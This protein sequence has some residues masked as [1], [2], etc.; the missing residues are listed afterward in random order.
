MSRRRRS[1]KLDAVDP[2]ARVPRAP[3]T[4]RPSTA[5]SS[6]SR[7]SSGRSRSRSQTRSLDEW[8]TYLRWQLV[9][10]FAAEAGGAFDAEN[11]HFF[12][13][14]LNGTPEQRPRWKRMLDEEENYLGDALGQL[15]VAALLLAARRRQRY[16][17]LTDEIFARVPRAHRRAR[18]DERRDEGSARC[19]KLDAVTKKVGY[20]DSWRTTRATT[21]TARRSSAT[22]MR[23]NVWRSDY[24]IAKLHKPV[25]RTEWEMTPQTYNAY[26]NPSN[27]EIV[28]PAAVFILPGIADSLVD[29]AIVYALRRRHDDRPRDHARLRRPGPPVRRAGQPRELVDAGGR[30]GVQRA[31]PR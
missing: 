23:G 14:I 2:L 8:K 4:S 28:L 27:N 11:F 5:S 22:V 15:Y 12:G 30:E 3:A 17:K 21:S 16:E 26:Y 31:A 29:D 10:T 24:D 9:D 18:L 1:T 7:S 13:T 6:A 25:D 19:S 20:P